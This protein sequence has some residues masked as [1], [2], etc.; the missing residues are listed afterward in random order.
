MADAQE[1]LPPEPSRT[2]YTGAPAL[3]PCAT[4]MPFAFP[5]DAKFRIDL[6]PDGTWQECL[7]LMLNEGILQ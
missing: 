2:C 5:L 7:E 6:G 4:V 3:T 1:A